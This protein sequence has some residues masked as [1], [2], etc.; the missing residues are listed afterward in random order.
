MREG[1]PAMA[2][3]CLDLCQAL[4]SQGKAFTFSLTHTG[5]SFTF[6]LDTRGEEKVESPSLRRPPARKKPS[7]ST[8]RRNARRKT[9]FMKKKNQPPARS[10]ESPAPPP[11]APGSWRSSPST[12]TSMLGVKLTRKP[13]SD[14][15]QYDGL[16]ELSITSETDDPAPQGQKTENFSEVLKLLEQL[17][18]N[19]EKDSQREEEERIKRKETRI[20]EKEENKQEKEE[21]LAIFKNIV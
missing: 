6:S 17:K 7:P 18:E 20:K 12:N 11:A 21:I 9:E 13:K 19:R 2:T 5:T 15:P 14:I 4:V 1:D 8:L 16:E 3:K 10:P